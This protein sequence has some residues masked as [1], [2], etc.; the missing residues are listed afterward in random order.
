[1]IVGVVAT[2]VSIYYYLRVIRALWMRPAAALAAGAVR[3][4][5]AAGAA[6]PG[7]RRCSASPSRWSRSSSRSRSSSSRSTRPRSLPL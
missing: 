6:A 5:A 1:M 2:A 3:R 7:R 4:L